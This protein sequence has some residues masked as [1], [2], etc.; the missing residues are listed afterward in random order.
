MLGKGHGGLYK[1]PIKEER[2]KRKA[3]RRDQ[4][5]FI[6]LIFERWQVVGLSETYWEKTTVAFTKP[7]QRKKEESKKLSGEREIRSSLLILDLKGGE[8]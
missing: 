4:I 5:K 7:Q 3:K 8:L 6:Y 1:A 2:R